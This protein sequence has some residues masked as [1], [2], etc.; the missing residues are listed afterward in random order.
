MRLKNTK[1][2]RNKKLLKG[3]ERSQNDYF[4]PRDPG[5]SFAQTH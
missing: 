4:A 2:K 1:G 3:N 5:L